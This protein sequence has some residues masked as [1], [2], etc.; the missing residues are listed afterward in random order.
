MS[1]NVKKT[2]K[3]Q[4]TFHR[5]FSRVPQKHHKILQTKNLLLRW[6]KRAIKNTKKK[7]YVIITPQFMKGLNFVNLT[8][9]CV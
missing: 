6:L 4:A 8:F 7:K 9:I 2:F 1:R 3:G 5:K